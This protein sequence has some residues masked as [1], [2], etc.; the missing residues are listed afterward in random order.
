MSLRSKGFKTVKPFKTT[1]F[2]YFVFFFALGIFCWAT[3]FASFQVAKDIDGNII[4]YKDGY[5]YTLAYN[6]TT[7]EIDRLPARAPTLNLQFIIAPIVLLYEFFIIAFGADVPH[8]RQLSWKIKFLML[9]GAIH[10]K[11]EEGKR[12]T[13]EWLQKRKKV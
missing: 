13:R 9:L 10:L 3:F 11:I 7:G 5:H 12:E 6:Q 2:D 1:K 4:E 8:L